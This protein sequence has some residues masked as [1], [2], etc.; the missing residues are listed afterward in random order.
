MGGSRRIRA[1]AVCAM[2][3]SLC[4]APVALGAPDIQPAD[5]VATDVDKPLGL[6][7]TGRAAKC[8]P[9]TEIASGGAYA[10]QAG[11]E[12][13][14]ALDVVSIHSSFPDSEGNRRLANAESGGANTELRVR[15]LCLP[16][17][18][19]NGATTVT[20]TTPI[21]TLAT[22]GLTLACPG[23]DA[24]V[25]G[26]AYT[27]LVGMPFDRSL[28]FAVVSSSTPTSDGLGWYAAAWNNSGVT[29]IEMTVV[30]V[31][32]P[33]ERVGEPRIKTK[34]V[35]VSGQG[36]EPSA[37][38][39]CGGKRRALAGGAYWHGGGGTPDP[40]LSDNAR[41]SGSVSLQKGRRWYADGYT[42]SN[43]SASMRVVAVC[44]PA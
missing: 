36:L 29:N 16:R 39:R 13:P 20:Q 6:G 9:G 5:L 25:T 31:C 12:R 37:I 33:A 2:A 22:G 43:V 8:R 21:A 3:L 35:A 38:V 27:H 4:T 19:L 7:T 30:I 40:G 41:A 18:Q 24:V 34:D 14:E 11:V 23:G 15:A 32:L 44:L 1:A 17:N 42:I 28:D 10:H 26:G